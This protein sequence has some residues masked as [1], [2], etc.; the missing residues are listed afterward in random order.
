MW[1]FVRPDRFPVAE[2]LLVAPVSEFAI[3]AQTTTARSLSF[4]SLPLDIYY[5][6]SN[7][8]DLC[9]I[10]SLSALTKAVRAF[11]IPHV[12]ALVSRY[13]IK[14]EPYHLP[15][16]PPCPRGDEEQVW[17]AGQWEFGGIKGDD[18]RARIP[19]LAYAQACGKSRSMRNRR[20]IWGIVDQIEEI[21]RRRGLLPF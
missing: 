20:R 1:A 2:A 6:I 15:V 21:A 10:T 7:H 19:W 4:D 11:L 14:H 17:W 3:H 18:M 9:G 8:L 16:S 12:D 13:M 5:S